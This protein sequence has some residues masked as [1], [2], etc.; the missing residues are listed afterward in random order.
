MMDVRRHTDELQACMGGDQGRKSAWDEMWCRK[1][2][3]MEGDTDG[4]GEGE[5]WIVGTVT[6]RMPGQKVSLR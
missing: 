5:R 1:G 4:M 6:M 3:L 2:K